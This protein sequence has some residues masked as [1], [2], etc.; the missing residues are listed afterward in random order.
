MRSPFRFAFLAMLT[1]VALYACG[2]G[3]APASSGTGVTQAQVQSMINAAVAPLQQQVN[4]LQSELANVGQSPAVFIRAPNAPTVTLKRQVS[5]SQKFSPSSSCTGLGTL[6]GRPTTSD[7]ITSN[8]ISGVSCSGY[9]FTVSAAATS[10]QNAYIQGLLSEASIYL[11]APNCTG[12][13]YIGVGFQGLSQGAVSNGAVFASPEPY[14]T[15][16]VIYMLTA[17]ETPVSVNAESY[18]NG[19]CFPASGTAMVLYALVP[20]DP[21]VSGVPS[22]PIP[23]PVMIN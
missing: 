7:P 14:T 20:N 2:S 3:A 23:G 21:T 13:A 15:T 5:T 18:W 17:G 1:S 4:T 16:Q 22:A 12:N 6:T 19:G 11:D 9:Y 10:A 8:L